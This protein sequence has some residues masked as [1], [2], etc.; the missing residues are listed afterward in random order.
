M[1]GE[2]PA[3]S[4]AW[5]EPEIVTGF[6]G[7]SHV[8]CDQCQYGLVHPETQQPIRKR[9]QFVGQPKVVKYLSKKCPGRHQ[10]A[11]IEGNVRIDDLSVRLST[12]CGAYPPALCRAILKGAEEFLA[13]EERSEEVLYEEVFAEE[14][15][16]AGDDL[17]ESDGDWAQGRES[18][19][20]ETRKRQRR[21]GESRIHLDE[22]QA[23]GE[24]EPPLVMKGGP[25]PDQRFPVA[26]EIQRA[27][28]HAHRQLGHPSRQTMLRML[29]L[30][31]AAPAAIQ[32]A[33][34]WRCDVCASRAKPKH[35]TASAPGVRPYGFNK[36]HQVD[37]K[38][39]KDHRG[40]K[41][42]FLS[43]IDVGTSY[44][45]A[46]MLKTRKSE[47][48]ASKWHRHWIANYG[49]PG[50]L[51]HD[52][53]G[54]FEKGFTALLEDLSMP[55]VVTGSHA[56]WQLSFAERHGG[57]LELV[58]GAV[59]AEH[60]TEGFSAMKLALSAAV[61]G[62]NATITK[63]GY[64]PAQRVFGHEVR[65][66]GLTEEE[67]AASF[68]EALGAEGEVA[69]AHKMRMTARMALLRSDVQEKLRRAV[70]RKPHKSQQ[71]FVPGCRIYFW[72]PAKAQKRYVPGTWRGP[73]TVLC[74]EATNR[75]FVSW[76]GRCLLLARENM[77]LATGEELALQ[78]PA[79][80]DLRELSRVLRDPE[81]D[82]TFKDA[83]LE[84]P[85]PKPK[86]TLGRLQLQVRGQEMMKGLRS[87]KR[88]IQDHPYPAG[89]R[90]KRRKM[91]VDRKR[92]QAL[93]APAEVSQPQRRRSK[94][95]QDAPE[96]PKAEEAPQPKPVIA[97]SPPDE[98]DDCSPVPTTPIE[99][100][101][102]RSPSPVTK[103]VEAHE[104]P[105]PP[106][107][108]EV[109]VPEDEWDDVFQD[110]VRSILEGPPLRDLRAELLDDVPHQ[111]KKKADEASKE[112]EE[113]VPKRLKAAYVFALSATVHDQRAK[114]NQW[115]SKHELALLRHLTGLDVT[116]AR[117]HTA[118]RKRLQ[119]PPKARDRARTSILIGRDPSMTLVI[120]ENATEVQKHPKKKTA[121]E[122]KGLTIFHNK[123]PKKEV[124]HKAYVAVPDGIV[125]VKMNGSEM[126]EFEQEWRQEMMDILMADALFL[127]LKTNKKE[128]DPRCFDP[129]ERKAFDAADRKEWQQWI[130]HKV[131]RVV[132]PAEAR[133]IPKDQIIHLPM[134]FVRTNKATERL[135]P[136]VA[137]SR[138]IIPGHLDP[139]VGQHRTD[140]PTA[141]VLATRILKFLAVSR[142]YVL[143]I[144]DVSTAFLRGKG[145]LRK[146]FVRAP[147]EG[148]PAG[149]GMPA[150]RP[151]ALMQVLKSAYGL[152]E[153][154]RLWYLR[155]K[156]VLEGTGLKELAAS[157]STFVA[158]ENGASYAMCA[159]HVDDGL[160]AGREDDPRFHRIKEAITEAFQIKKWQKLEEGKPLTFLGVEI[161]K[162]KIGI[163]DRMD[164]YI[165]EI[166][167]PEKPKDKGPLDEVG[168]TNFRKLVMRLRWP[169]QHCVSQ[170]LYAVSWLAQRVN[171]ATGEDMV[172]AIQ[173]LHQMKEEAKQGRARL[174][175]QPIPEDQ[176][177]VVSYFDASLGKEAAGKSQLASA[178]F[179]AHS[180]AM[181]GPAP[182]NLLEFATTKSTRVVRSSMAAEACSMCLASDKH[183]YLRLLLQM[184]VTGDQSVA[185]KWRTELKVP[186]ALVSDAKAL[187][188]HMVTTG[189][190]PTE[191]Q[192]LLDVLVCKDLVENGVVK[193]KWVPTHKQYADC[194]TKLMK[195][196]LWD[197]FFKEGKISLR[198]TPQEAIEEEHR[199]G[200]RKAQRQRRKERM[201]KL[202]PPSR[203]LPKKPR[204]S[205]STGCTSQT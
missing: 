21:E 62:K 166:E 8:Q 105:V 78:E 33:K 86:M 112:P 108:H 143:Y 73:A 158:S 31:G 189:Q 165:Q 128:L 146:L 77:R 39:C 103:P 106:E 89:Q 131:I 1:V 135:A 198:E 37:L 154:P 70:L 4:L 93:E 15:M 28:E 132:P 130:D 148:L 61:Q 42:V 160:L 119:P 139:E 19:D 102:S 137:K 71:E 12:W 94:R 68:A 174:W 69:R 75:F 191:R 126:A 199:R 60:Q 49:A 30:A 127:K 161:F 183:L 5:K 34:Q 177:D 11:H 63:D 149:D 153:S 67:E 22:V 54:E 195:A 116:A 201:L 200:L 64:T 53:G 205:R 181:N 193:M 80:T 124:K 76:R 90:Q 47:Y 27:V 204:V 111:F 59:V 81:G 96:G 10:H 190:V 82:R 187:F 58:L 115:L 95:I 56:G 46:V 197:A 20:E 110:E 29:Q 155:A 14:K 23:D 85:P 101:R 35:P 87:A 182:A 57:L 9:T 2:N 120:E 156:E 171:E 26:K 172:R 98:H 162:E 16:M 144:F 100:P 170:L 157:R 186:G 41:Y 140:S 65:F 145:L 134:R 45:Q 52:Q 109:P 74:K 122:W 173:T 107:P 151:L 167:I 3:P 36:Q 123:R 152:T 203:Q 40:K 7:L 44:H 178:H 91:I 194:M 202:H 192:T 142:G 159:L 118:P 99:T 104:V 141:A 117:L 175:Y 169:A 180:G 17:V 66:P 84:K 164:R 150:I 55:S 18:S 179:V 125:E 43:M 147:P 163:T 50:K 129:E 184:M 92:R 188:D 32:H 72:S 114:Q 48:V 185:E 79:A 13:D 196:V 38:Y 25:N 168:R 133:R 136:L 24:A 83:S 6:D 97:S 138:I 176:M 88:L 121:F 113:P 51:T